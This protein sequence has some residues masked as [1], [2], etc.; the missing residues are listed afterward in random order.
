MILSRN[1]YSSEDIIRSIQQYHC[2]SFDIFDTL[3]KRCVS[4]PNDIFT[5]VAREYNSLHQDKIN[6]QEFANHRVKAGRLAIKQAFHEGKEERTLDDIYQL[7]NNRYGNTCLI[8]KQLEI[9]RE[10]DCCKQNVE[11]KQVYDWCLKNSKIVYI[12]SDMYL[13]QYVIEKILKNCNYTG[14]HKLFL[15]STL[16]KKKSTGSLFQ[17]IIET[18]HI[19][20][21]TFVHIG[22]HI[23]TDYFK[24]KQYGLKAIKIPR[25]IDNCRFER[26]GMSFPNDFKYNQLQSV[27]GNFSQKSW[28]PYFQY[29]FECIGP[30]LYGFC[31]WLHKRSVTI[32]CKQLFF[33]SRDGYIMQLAYNRLFKENALPNNYMYVSRKSLF[34]SQVWMNPYLEDILKQETPYHYWNVDELCEM[35]DINKDFGYKVWLSCGLAKEERLIKKRLLNDKRVTN[36]FERVKPIMLSTSKK[37]FEI[38]VDYLRQENFRGQV[39][40]VDVG[41]AGAIQRYL[42]RISEHVNWDISIYGF[43]LGLKPVTVMGVNAE[44]YIPQKERPSMFCSNLMEYP[45]TKNEGTT[46]DYCRKTNGTIEPIIATYEFE[47]M[48]D[49]EFTKDM[50]Q[51]AMYFIELMECGYGVQPINWQIGYHNVKNVTKHPRFSDVC[52]LGG[53][54]HVNHGQKHYLAEPDK[55]LKYIFDPQKLKIDLADSGWKIGFLKK[56]LKLPLPYDWILTVLRKL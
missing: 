13:P 14:Y 29:G 5:R 41:W 36:F 12:S 19:D 25:Q 26:Y 22:D 42:Q 56:L 48:I 11:M 21:K 50:Q 49:K 1:S 4:K 9:E 37:K 44:A 52:L 45:F 55:L 31:T 32:G 7:L 23:K 6:E 35:L 24:A 20:K 18:E 47:D 43:Y 27:I 3:V 39:G 38:I 8:L 33:L 15:S 46:K 10:I 28:S 17:Y 40:I 53:L 51:G 54:S 30:M 34:G 16:N 2:V